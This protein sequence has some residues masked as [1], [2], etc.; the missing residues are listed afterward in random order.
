MRGFGWMGRLNA[1][2][3]EQLKKR[4]RPF[5]VVLMLITCC[6]MVIVGVV[7]YILITKG[8]EKMTGGSSLKQAMTFHMATDPFDPWQTVERQTITFD[9]Q[10]PFWTEVR[11]KDVREGDTFF[12]DPADD[13]QIWVPW[14]E[15]RDIDPKNWRNGIHGTWVAADG[16]RI[17]TPKTAQR[18]RAK[19]PS[20]TAP[21]QR[22][23]IG[24]LIGALGDSVTVD[25][26][27]LP[28][29]KRKAGPFY[30]GLLQVFTVRRP[31]KALYLTTNTQQEIGAYKKLDGRIT[32]VV[33]QKRRR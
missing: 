28:S 26:Q 22:Q 25:E 6:I 21:M 16:F 5:A 33:T 2:R 32:V 29:I 30:V 4:S 17:A 31:F 10:H 23:C 11:F 18:Q 27:A 7:A 12:I 19:T 13:E 15:L 24:A 20:D 1:W 8:I 9:A 14:F 3:K